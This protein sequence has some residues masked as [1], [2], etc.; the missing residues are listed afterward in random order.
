MTVLNTIDI[1]L[2]DIGSLCALRD[3]VQL[4]VL[5]QC[6]MSLVSV[7]Q[8]CHSIATSIEINK[9]YNLQV[10]VGATEVRGQLLHIHCRT[11]VPM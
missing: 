2:E 3:E 7:R 9:G 1:T 10:L 5:R 6:R 11:K 8:N 4:M